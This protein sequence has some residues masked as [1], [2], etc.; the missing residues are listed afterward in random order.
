MTVLFPDLRL[1][2]AEICGIISVI[3]NFFQVA[4][5]KNSLLQSFQNEARSFYLGYNCNLNV[6]DN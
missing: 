1:R 4:G 3:R 2:Y 5:T 6:I